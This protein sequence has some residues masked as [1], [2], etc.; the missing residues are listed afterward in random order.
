[1]II[2]KPFNVTTKPLKWIPP[3][4]YLIDSQT[5]NLSTRNILVTD[6]T[7]NNFVAS[8]T[9]SVTLPYTNFGNYN[10]K[11]NNK[12][13]FPEIAQ[14]SSQTYL[15]S[16]SIT[17]HLSSY[18]YIRSLSTSNF[19]TYNVFGNEVNTFKIPNVIGFKMGPS[20]RINNCRVTIPNLLYTA[21]FG[22]SSDT[23]NGGNWDLVGYFPY[24]DINVST[25]G[26]LS[27]I[28]R[29]GA[30]D[31][32]GGW[33]VDTCGFYLKIDPELIANSHKIILE[34]D[35][36]TND[37]AGINKHGIG[38]WD[39]TNQPTGANG[40]PNYNFYGTWGGSK[41][42]YLPN[43]MTVNTLSATKNFSNNVKYSRTIILENK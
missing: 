6:I 28:G 41:L 29:Q 14:I 18:T 9:Y 30:N 1:M 42:A 38:F 20:I 7:T 11:E 17:N 2:K 25:Q 10:L 15:A 31:L 12:Y 27:G 19:G 24:H 26:G 34:Y 39:N 16:S 32:G 35:F 22:L 23:D 8:S 21:Q 33:S 40:G 36:Y 37:L 13:V 5:I 3:V 43:I 4:S